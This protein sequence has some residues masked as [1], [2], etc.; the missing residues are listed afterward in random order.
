MATAHRLLDQ[1]RINLT[2]ES[3]A[4]GYTLVIWGSG[5]ALINA[6]GI[7]ATY[8]ILGYIIGALT[9]FALLAAPVYGGFLGRIPNQKDEEM[10]VASMVHL[11]A[12][13]GSIAIATWIASTLP[14]ETAF[15]LCGVNA[16]VTYNLLMLAEVAVTEEL[17]SHPWHQ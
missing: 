16:S 5:A 15:F 2:D 1:L 17:A 6:F 10:V 13:L 3:K 7:P 11:I 4:Y 12:A 9:G 14:A 8:N